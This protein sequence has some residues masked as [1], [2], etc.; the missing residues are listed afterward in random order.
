MIYKR[1]VV[2]SATPLFVDFFYCDLLCHLA[3]HV[4]VTLICEHSTKEEQLLK[5]GVKRCYIK[6][7]RRPQMDDPITMARLFANRALFNGALVVTWGFKAS[8]LCYLMKK[9]RLARFRQLTFFQ[10]EAWVTSGRLT[11]YFYSA[12]DRELILNSDF[13]F[14][15]SAGEA[16]F[17]QHALKLKSSSSFFPER[18]LQMVH[19]GSLVGVDVSRFRPATSEQ[20]FAVRQSFGMSTEDFVIG[21]I[22]RLSKDKGLDFLIS[23]FT[24][25]CAERRNVKL[26]LGGVREWDGLDELVRACP[27]EIRSQIII[28][29]FTQQPEV[30]LQCLNVFVSPTLREGFGQAAIEA[31]ACGVPVLISKIYG[32][33]S[34]VIP[35]LGKRIHLKQ[36]ETWLNELFSIYDNRTCNLSSAHQKDAWKQI[37]TKFG[38]KLVQDELLRK[39]LNA[40]E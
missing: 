19:H 31:Q 24:T 40:M 20:K 4:Q 3:R 13:S 32:T 37:S 15:A 23:L 11:R 33:K 30:Y 27:D 16:S 12:L 28:A 22:G 2:V 5:R 35:G 6:V 39:L 38:S 29:P 18:Q 26:F 21:Y 36:R 25:V 1:I 34:T 14:V 10:G 9:L 7:G 8:L 17:L